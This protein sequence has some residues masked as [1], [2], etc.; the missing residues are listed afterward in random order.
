MPTLAERIDQARVDERLA[1]PHDVWQVREDQVQAA[2]RFGSVYQDELT[3]ERR[4]YLSLVPDTVHAVAQLELDLP[5]YSERAEIRRRLADKIERE[6]LPIFCPRW[7]ERYPEKLRSAR[8]T[9]CFGV[10][11][12]T[13]RPIVFW[14]EKAGL[15]RL[16]P[17]DARE[18]AQR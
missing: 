5:A 13:G 14:D 6:V 12:D 11:R 7:L 9:G 4:S 18:E 10:R 8:R 3:H 17:D 1:A 15:S 16:C 2:G